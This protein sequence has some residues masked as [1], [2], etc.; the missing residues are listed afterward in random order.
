MNP[1][2]ITGEIVDAMRND[3]ASGQTGEIMIKGLERLLAVYL[4]IAI[5]RAQKFLL[6]GIHAQD[7]VASLKKLLDEMG[8][9]AELGVAMRRVTPGQHFGHLAPGKTEPIENPSHDAGGGK[10]GLFLQAF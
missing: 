6:L 5:E 4:A 2:L 3:N 8:Q 1:A 10:D 7:R 9:M